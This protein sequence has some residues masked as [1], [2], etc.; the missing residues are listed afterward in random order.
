MAKDTTRIAVIMPNDL[1]AK[2]VE[3]AQA[4]RRSLNSYLVVLLEQH[5]ADKAKTDA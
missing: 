5:A 4:E 1:H 2:L 3:L